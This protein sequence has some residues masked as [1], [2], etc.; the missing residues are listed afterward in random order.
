M[1]V[2]LRPPE[3]DPGDVFQDLPA[4]L[5]DVE[6]HG[7][8]VAG[9]WPLLAVEQETALPDLDHAIT[10]RVQVAAAAGR[11][12]GPAGDARQE[13]RRLDLGSSRKFRSILFFLGGVTQGHHWSI[14]HHRSQ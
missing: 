7:R 2:Q 1:T 3:G 11:R 13:R 4:T 6:L 9:Q 8:V 14:D 12:D 10:H 5:H